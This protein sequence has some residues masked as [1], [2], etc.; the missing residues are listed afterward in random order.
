MFQISDLPQKTNPN[1][2]AQQIVSSSDVIGKLKNAG[3]DAEESILIDMME[4]W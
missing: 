1:A 2:S 4:N 3:C